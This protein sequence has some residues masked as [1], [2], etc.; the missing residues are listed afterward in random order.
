MLLGATSS[1]KVSRYETFA[2]MPALDS[3]FAYEI[4]FSTQARELFAGYY[5]AIDREVRKRA[6]SIL[7]KLTT[8]FAGVHPPQAARKVVLLRS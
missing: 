2:R 4:I 6:K 1:T 3:I 5:R 8:H 7:K